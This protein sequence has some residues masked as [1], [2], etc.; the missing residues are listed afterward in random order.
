MSIIRH[1]QIV[2]YSTSS[3]LT[4]A[5]VASN[6]ITFTKGDGS[7]FPI[8]VN[9]GSGGGGGG[10][11][12]G[13]NTDIQFNDSTTFNGSSNFTF[14]KNT[15]LVNIQKAGSQNVFPPIIKSTTSSLEINGN[16]NVLGK[17]QTNEANIYTQTFPSIRT[18]PFG[19]NVEWD[20]GK[21]GSIALITLSDNATDFDINYF[22]DLLGY[23][24]GTLIVRQDSTGGWSFALPTSMGGGSISNYV[25][26]NGGGTYNPTPNPNAYDI[27]EFVCIN[28]I[29]FWS[30]KYNFTN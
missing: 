23:A 1:P 13:T 26:N 27:L 29:I 30:I 8:T 24:K 15:N 21:S 14:N 4:T 10:T 9:T 16:I 11:P 5:S 6:T 7:T 17:I 28:K 19:K 20:I 18:L 3:F 2:P 25:E 22:G 12:G